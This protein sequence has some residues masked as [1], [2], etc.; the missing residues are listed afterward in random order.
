MEVVGHAFIALSRKFS[1]VVV[2]ANGVQALRVIP[3]EQ[4]LLCGLV[5]IL[6]NAA[7]IRAFWLHLFAV[8]T[9][10]RIG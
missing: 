5:Q 8:S 9:V 7:A 3:N 10:G 1:S 6:R 2:S 4:P